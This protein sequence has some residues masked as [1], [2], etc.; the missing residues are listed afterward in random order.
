MK[1]EGGPVV[2]P[3][4]PPDINVEHWQESIRLLRSLKLDTIHLTHYGGIPAED[5]PNHLDMLEQRLLSWAEWMRPQYEQGNDPKEVTPVFQAH[6]QKQLKAAG[7]EG[8]LLEIYENANP[9]WM[10]V[11][12]LLRYWR[13]KL[14]A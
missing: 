7:V 8:E 14:K 11:A 13:K 5:I 4:P 1:I 9:S 3:C 10:S 6:V 12:G 2:P